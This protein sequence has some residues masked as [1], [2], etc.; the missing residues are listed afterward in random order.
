MFPIPC[1]HC[2]SRGWVLFGL[3]G[4]DWPERCPAC[5]GVG[6]VRNLEALATRLDVHPRVMRRI[7]TCKRVLPELALQVLVRLHD[8]FPQEVAA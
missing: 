1:R 8:C 7:A 6:E 2:R 3:A 5:R 4:R